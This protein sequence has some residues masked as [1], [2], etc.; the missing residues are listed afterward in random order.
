MYF[1]TDCVLYG[2]QKYQMGRK[3]SLSKKT[4]KTMANKNEKKDKHR[5]HNTTL[6]T[7]AVARRTL[8]N[9]G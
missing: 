3:K 2:L 6:K 7:K 4:D 1:N 5:T 8:P 9:L